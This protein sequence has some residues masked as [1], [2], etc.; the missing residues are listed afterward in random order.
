MFEFT[1]FCVYLGENTGENI[2]MASK[3]P[4][5]T[6]DLS[7]IKNGV[8]S[9][10]FRVSC[11]GS[12][13]DLYTGIVLAKNQWN[14]K[15][16]KVKQGCKVN[17]MP[18][19]ILNDTLLEME[20]FI[21]E[22]F[23]SVFLRKDAISLT[24]LKSRFN[25]KFKASS[26]SQSEEFFYLM[27]NYIENTEITRT[28][29]KEYRQEWRRVADSLREYNPNLR[30]SDLTEATLNG[31]LKHLSATMYND[32]INKN[33]QKLREFVLWAK[34]KK[35]PV[36][37][38]FFT[39]RPRLKEAKNDVQYLEVEELQTIINLDLEL[40]STMDVV[41][42]LFVFQ[43]FTALRF[44]DLANLRKEDIYYNESDNKH[45]IK[46]LTQKDKDIIHFPLAKY[47]V[48]IYKKYKDNDYDNGKM[49]HVSSNPKYNA[50]LKKLG[51]LA[52]LKGYWVSH[53]FRLEEEEEER[54]PR[55]SLT[56]H[57]PRRTFVSLTLNANVSDELVARI[58]S[59]SDVKAMKPYIKLTEKGKAFVIDTLEGLVGQTM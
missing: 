33:L 58:T 42:D 39:F 9:V 40:G 46:L 45:Y 19:N 14:E 57:I 48:D 3:L 22:Y 25:A 43:C 16:S 15:N 34:S 50:H 36:H 31:Y 27:N 49:F 13:T 18:Y 21:S 32:K 51:K 30:F 37:D 28:W 26:K 5:W 38:D 20:E 24:D 10:R 59:H 2:I 12:R 6:L 41:R 1:L 23:N 55:T 4:T 53:R 54:I 7:D 52:N 44:G 11:Q 8:G 56:A 17:K 35:Y 47:A 29:G